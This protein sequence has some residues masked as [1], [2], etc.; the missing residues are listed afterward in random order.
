[1]SSGGL[2]RQPRTWQPST[3]SSKCLNKVKRGGQL[4]KP[5]Y[6]C[7]G[8]IEKETIV[9]DDAAVRG[10]AIAV[11]L[12]RPLWRCSE[13]VSLYDAAGE[14]KMHSTVKINV[15]TILPI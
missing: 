9:D 12:P 13:C 7:Q 15:N 4:L 2:V 1:M 11:T 14:E 10:I 5:G 3:F 8:N 6:R